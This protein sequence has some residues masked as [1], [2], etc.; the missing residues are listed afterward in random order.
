MEHQPIA[1]DLE[2][3]ERID[4]V[5]YDMTPPPTSEH[6]RIVGNLFREI[7]VYLKGKTCTAYPAPFGVWLDTEDDGNYVEPDIT[8]VCDP[9]KIQP[10]G[11]VGVPDMVIEVLSPATAKKDKAAKL[12]A[13]RTAGVREYW[14]ADPS[15]QIVEVYRLADD[16]VFPTVYGKDDTVAVGI[17]GDL[18]I[19][20]QDIF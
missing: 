17:F 6:Q 18:H 5:I 14:I 4:G 9:S 1:A 15:N 20:M 3:W 12:R 7:R 10:K 19:N 16:N 8:I 13:Y 2:R 11:C